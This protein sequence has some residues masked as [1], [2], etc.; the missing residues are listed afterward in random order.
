MRRP[1]SPLLTQLL[2]RV[3]SQRFEAVE[4]AARELAQP[5]PFH[6]VGEAGE[7]VFAGGWAHYGAP[8]HYVSFYRDGS[9]IVHVRGQAQQTSDVG[10]TIFYLPARYCPEA[11]ATL[12][13]FTLYNSGAPAALPIFVRPSGEV[14]TTGTG[15]NLRRRVSLDGIRF[16]AY[17]P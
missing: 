8:F 10:T 17:E 2:A 5:E 3:E 12:T 6:I 11:D 16:P 1:E 9:S 15:P 14:R 4:A 13:C 7:P